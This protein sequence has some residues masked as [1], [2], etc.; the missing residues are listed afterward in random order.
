MDDDLRS[1]NDQVKDELFGIYKRMTD[2]EERR[3]AEIK[4]RRE[5]FTAELASD[6]GLE[7]NEANTEA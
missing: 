4:Q 2:P 3:K 1:G 6:A 7:Y 5:L